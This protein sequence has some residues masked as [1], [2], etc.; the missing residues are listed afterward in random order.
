M[1]A[2]RIVVTGASGGIGAATARALAAPGSRLILH[3]HMQEV[4]ARTLA[5]EL[6][7]QGAQAYPL[8]ADFADLDAVDR[9]AALARDR[10]GP[11]EV[12]VHAAGMSQ[13]AL[14]QD[15]PL[16]EW[17]KLH[18]AHLGAAYRL[19]QAMLPDMVRQGFGR[20]VLIGSVFGQRGG[21]ME[22]AYAA[23]KAGYGALARALLGEVGRSRVTVNVV[24]PG[25]IATP[26][27]GRLDPEE[28]GRLEETIPAGRLG[29]PEE[30]ADAVRFLVSPDAAYIS[31]I[32]LAVDGGYST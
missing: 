19:L 12:L 1:Q 26:M 16:S 5:G 8:G 11:P 28:R 7:Q 15:L 25:A 29:R 4:L 13:F 27:L 23:A 24:A 22:A 32:T 31:G 10:I 3:Y 6:S 14:L 2:T 17:R 18:D 30:V 21:A 9:F 20:V